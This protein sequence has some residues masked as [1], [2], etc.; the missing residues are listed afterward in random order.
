M[1]LLIPE[2]IVSFLLVFKVG[3]GIGILKTLQEPVQKANM[4]HFSPSIPNPTINNIGHSILHIKLP[5]QPFINPNIH[6]SPPPQLLKLFESVK[7][8]STDPLFKF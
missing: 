5:T 3:K 1:F 2:S 4:R 6:I 8:L 7:F